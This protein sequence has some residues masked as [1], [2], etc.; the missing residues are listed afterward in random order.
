[1]SPEETEARGVLTFAIQACLPVFDYLGCIRYEL[2]CLTDKECRQI[3][4][5]YPFSYEQ[6]RKAFP[7]FENKDLKNEQ[8][9]T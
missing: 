9:R 8:T 5:N 7:Q 3:S 1:M 4:V 6:I 2:P